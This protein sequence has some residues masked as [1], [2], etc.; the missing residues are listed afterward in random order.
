MDIISLMTEFSRDAG[1]SVPFSPGEQ[2]SLQ[3]EDGVI[4]DVEHDADIDTV[5]LKTVVGT[6]PADAEARSALLVRLLVANGF[7]PVTRYASIACEAD[8]QTLVLMA[9]IA[10]PNASSAALSE[11]L[12]Q[13]AAQAGPVADAIASAGR[14][15]AGGN[16]AMPNHEAMPRA[17]LE[18]LSRQA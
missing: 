11:R 9:K 2:I 4:V 6:L 16:H 3:F 1:I 15:V 18:M 10:V 14:H 17:A 12:Q 5:Y 13:L 8:K 7:D